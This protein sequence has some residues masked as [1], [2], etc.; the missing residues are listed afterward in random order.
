MNK[1]VAAAVI[2]AR[3]AFSQPFIPTEKALYKEHT[4]AGVIELPKTR[5]DTGAMLAAPL[6]ANPEIKF[7]V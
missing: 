2:A 6:S 4:P 5:T 7:F 3:T 1:T